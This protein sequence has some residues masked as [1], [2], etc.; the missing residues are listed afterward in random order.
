M[1][2]LFEIQELCDRVNKAA[3]SLAADM[4][5][6]ENSVQ[7]VYDNE[8][9]TAADAAV[10]LFHTREAYDALDAQRK[11]LYHQKDFLEKGIVP[12]K[13]EKEG[14]DMVRVPEL[15]RSFSLQQKMS[16][17]FVDKEKGFEW[18]RSIGQ[19]DIIQETVNASTLTAFC[20]NL[21]IEEGI[22][23]PIEVV[24][25]NTYNTTGVSKYTP[26]GRK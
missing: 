18:L 17:S 21:I 3:D 20:R 26:K 4:E 9:A 6:L 19:E 11:R 22:E 15:A 10:A 25:V 24:R 2:S 23:P 16:A 14:V 13:M 7:A 1:S 8:S 5:K 12:S